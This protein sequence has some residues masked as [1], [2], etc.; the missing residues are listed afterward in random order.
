VSLVSSTVIVSSTIAK[1]AVQVAPISLISDDED[2]GEPICLVSD[3]DEIEIKTPPPKRMKQTKVESLFERQL[4][5]QVY[6]IENL[7]ESLPYRFH[8]DS[9]RLWHH[10]DHRFGRLL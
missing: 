6:R 3:D 4:R 8:F 2:C 5:F 1:V 10:L 9:Q 7:P